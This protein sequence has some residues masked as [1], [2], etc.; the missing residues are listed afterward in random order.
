MSGP[1]YRFEIPAGT[2]C[3]IK[4]KVPQGEPD[5]GFKQYE[6]GSSVTGLE[7]HQTEKSA[8]FEVDH[9]GTTYTVCISK[10]KL[11]TIGWEE[12]E[13]RA[14]S[15]SEEQKSLVDNEPPPF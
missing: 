5:A 13:Q 3:L 9:S 12:S 15:Q 1:Q 8:M 7:V 2:S 11:L 14:P 6:T 4:K 10:K